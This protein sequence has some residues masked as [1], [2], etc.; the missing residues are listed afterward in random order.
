MGQ[1]VDKLSA[2]VIG[3]EVV[4]KEID[5]RT[6]NHQ[7]QTTFFPRILKECSSELYE[8]IA[9]IFRKF[10]DKVSRLWRQANVVPIF[11]KEGRK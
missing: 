5:L 2:I 8:P 3:R 10:L 1:E 11:K 9:M 4:S 7:G 6:L